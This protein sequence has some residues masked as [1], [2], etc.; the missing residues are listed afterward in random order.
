[1]IIVSGANGFIGSVLAKDLNNKGY[2]D[3]ICTD[4]IGLDQRSSLLKDV[5]YNSFLSEKELFPFLDKNKNSIQCIF[6]MGACSDTTEMDEDFLKENNTLYTQ[7]IFE[8]CSQTDTTLV[9]ASSGAVYG[10]GEHG[11]D[12]ENTSTNYKALNPYGWSKLNFDI[13]MENLSSLPINCYG[14]RFF[15]VYGPNEYHK[16]HMSSVVFKAYNQITETGRLKLFKSKNP[17]YK[18]GEQL[19]DFVYVKDISR[20]M[21]ELF[22][23]ENIKSGIYNMG[24]GKARTWLSLA[25]QVFKSMDK[26]LD[27]DWIDMPENLVNQYQYITEAKM[28]KLFGQ[29]LSQ[30]QW[31]LE[32]V[33]NDFFTNYLSLDS[34]YYAKK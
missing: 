32:D 14:V 13:W 26:P 23:G 8:F 18:D 2:T 34:P 24:Y 12:D 7:K 30:P 3:L 27:I 33:I 19:R 15:N 21:I 29:S 11:F 22:E 31:S 5:K 1:M 17:N 10:N 9:F 4:S 6:H 28:T 25:K 20:W 16:D